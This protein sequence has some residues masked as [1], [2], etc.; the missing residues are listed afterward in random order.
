MQN[1]RVD[2]RKW[3]ERW[4]EIDKLPGGG[5]GEAF[6]VEALE[7]GGRAFLKVLKQ[8]RDAE[9]RSRFVREA[10]AYE[11][12]V[13]KASPKL[14]ETNAHLHSDQTANL[15]I[16]TEFVPG[17]TLSTA[18]E[19]KGR[20]G[21]SEALSSVAALL[22]VVGYLHDNGCIHRD[23][24]PDNIILRDGDPRTPVLVDFGLNYMNQED[25]GLKTEDGQEL[26]NRFL[27]LPELSAGSR[28]KQDP[29]SDLAFVSGILFFMLTGQS[30]ANLADEHGKLPHQRLNG[31]LLQ[32]G[33]LEKLPEL[34]RLFDRAF[35][36]RPVDRYTSAS[37]LMEALKKVSSYI[38]APGDDANAILAEI[39]TALDAE[40]HQRSAQCRQSLD[41]VM[42]NIQ[43]HHGHIAV[44]LEPYSPYQTGFHNKVNSI[45]NQLGF[46]RKEDQSINFLSEIDAEVV[47]D[48]L[49]VTM[50][51]ETV[52]RTDAIEPVFSED[53]SNAVRLVFVKGIQSL[54]AR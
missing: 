29:A 8:Q 36:Q 32:D 28:G 23:I 54:M 11:T 1:P 46:C 48:E 30:P 50:D 45:H 40:H 22:D 21:L 38:P 6:V 41:K 4:K 12:F 37:E 52:L 16:A 20:F 24:K 14:I 27:R 19:E 17:P 33:D 44:Q 51:D 5:Q 26:G 31:E 53:F 34:L 42:K 49:V 18:L 47:G 13:H 39:R 15:Y 35:Q 3:K 43:E 25:A 7:G 2:V 9:R 10:I